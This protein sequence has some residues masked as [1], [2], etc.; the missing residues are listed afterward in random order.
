M[1]WLLLAMLAGC[2]F[3][4]GGGAVPGDGPDAAPP[5]DTPDAPDAPPSQVCLG[6]GEFRICVDEPTMP[7]S[8]G[9]TNPTIDT[10]ADPPECTFVSQPDRPSLCVIAATTITIDD[11][12]LFVTG[13][14]PLVLLARDTIRIGRGVD[15]S[16]HQMGPATGAGFDS[17]ACDASGNGGND[18]NGGDGGAGGSFGS[19]GGNGGAAGGTSQ[20]PSAGAVTTPALFLRGGCKGGNGGNGNGGGTGGAGNHGGGAVLL[21]AGQSIAIDGFVNASGGG[22]GRGL[23]SK[24]GGGGRARAA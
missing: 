7:F 23:N 12:I 9:A 8:V 19:V 22:G 10:D 24:G 11:S 21:L 15:V 14:H 6:D 13:S 18:N 1:R 2:D 3:E 17:A 20:G 16:S 4:R 5:K